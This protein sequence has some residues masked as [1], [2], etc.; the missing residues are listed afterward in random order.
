MEHIKPVE[1]IV[2]AIRE[3]MNKTIDQYIGAV[4]DV[5]R[6]YIMGKWS[7]LSAAFTVAVETLAKVRKEVKE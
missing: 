3:L 7:G 5:D 2:A 6:K 1:E 4:D